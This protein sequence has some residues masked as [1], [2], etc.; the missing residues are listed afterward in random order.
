MKSRCQC[1]RNDTEKKLLQILHR[2]EE[3]LTLSSNESQPATDHV[4]RLHIV[5]GRRWSAFWIEPRL[6][7]TS[8]GSLFF[9]DRLTR[10]TSDSESE[11]PGSNPGPQAISCCTVLGVVS[12]VGNH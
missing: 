7:S 10:R 1:E 12:S 3:E 4:A 11:N 6:A 5:E 2:S 8:R 9:G